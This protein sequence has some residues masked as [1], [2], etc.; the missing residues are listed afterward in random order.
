V[1]QLRK[2]IREVGHDML[3]PAD[4]QALTAIT[5][6]Y[7]ELKDL[8]ILA[9][10]PPEVTNQILDKSSTLAAAHKIGMRIP[11]TEVISHSSQLFELSSSFA[12]PW[13]LKPAKKEVREEE[14]KS[15]NLASA[16]E[17]TAKIPRGRKFNPPMLLQEYCGGA[18]VGVELLMHEGE[19]CAV[20]QHCRLKELPY[21][22]GVS[23]SAVA[24]EPSPKLVEN[25]IALLR[26]LR[27]EGPAMVEFKVNPDNGDA[28][29]M[30]VNGRYWGTIGLP[31]SAGIDFPLYHWQLL[32]GETPAV[33]DHYAA[34]TSWRWMA[35]HVVRLH[36]LLRA[37]RRSSAARAELRRTLSSFP[38]P[39][40][41]LIGDAM[42]SSSDPSPSILEA[43]HTVKVL[44]FCDLKELT[45]CIL[46]RAG[47][48]K[49]TE[50]C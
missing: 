24:E 2:F 13:V 29:F 49:T 10:P 21:T 11:K 8:L 46:P 1:E 9:C 27:W 30:E 50:Q 42:F 3:I 37:A 23:V 16:E 38:S 5:E 32:H 7:Y 39:S 33:P 47:R 18:G 19:C 15:L 4:D 40:K 48:D 14:I 36:G 17:L 22:G 35:G 44:F 28:V 43:L 20:F 34:G 6:H 45:G 41:I 26:V 12:F 25:S 31:I